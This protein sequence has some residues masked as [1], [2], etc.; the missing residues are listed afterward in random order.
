MITALHKTVD[1]QTL[2]VCGQLTKREIKAWQSEGYRLQEPQVNK[3]GIPV[4]G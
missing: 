2:T 4:E 3:H 1:G